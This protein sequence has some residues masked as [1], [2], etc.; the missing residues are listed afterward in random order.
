MLTQLELVNLCRVFEPSDFTRQNTVD[1]MEGS[2]PQNM[3]HEH[4]LLRSFIGMDEGTFILTR[5]GAFSSAPGGMKYLFVDCCSLK[6]CFCYRFSTFI[7]QI[8]GSP[9]FGFQRCSRAIK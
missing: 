2:T 9:L 6:G 1:R 4:E 7:V 5:R 8:V 3:M